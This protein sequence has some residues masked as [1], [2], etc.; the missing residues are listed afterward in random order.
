[1]FVFATWLMWH[2]QAMGMMETAEQEYQDVMSKKRIV[3]NDK[4]KIEVCA[5]S[6]PVSCQGMG[7]SPQC[8]TIP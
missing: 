7:P 4:K 8:G 2:C 6:F 3:A 5:S 1:M